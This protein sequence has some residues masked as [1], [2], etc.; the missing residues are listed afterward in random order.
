M[1][2][3]KIK[4][5]RVEKTIEVAC[6]AFRILIRYIFINECIGYIKYVSFDFKCQACDISHTTKQQKEQEKNFINSSSLNMSRQIFGDE[7]F[8]EI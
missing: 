5:E 1:R 7:I 6:E 4:M 2:L 8:T 3:D